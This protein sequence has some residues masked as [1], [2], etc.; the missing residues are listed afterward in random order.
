MKGTR[1]GSSDE[2]DKGRRKGEEVVMKE[3]KGRKKGEEGDK[4]RR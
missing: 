3:D 4:G 1:E 2:G